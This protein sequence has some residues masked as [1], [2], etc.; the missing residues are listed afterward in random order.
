MIETPHKLEILTLGGLQ[1]HLDGSPLTALTP[2]KV[3]ALLVYLACADRPQ[4][5]EMLAELLWEDRDQAQ[6]LTN[7]RATL[8]RL[9]QHVAPFLSITRD[10]LGIEPASAVWLDVRECLQ[11]IAGAGA[12]QRLTSNDAARLEAALDLYHGDFL[13]D[14][15][16]AESPGFETW[17]AEQRAYLRDRVFEGFHRLVTFYLR[18]GAFLQ[19]IALTQ[20][21]LALD[22][23]SEQAH[24]QLM[25]LLAQSGQRSAA[26][27]QYIR[28]RQ[29]LAAELDVDPEPTTNA[30]YEQIQSG[31]IGLRAQPRL[32]RLPVMLTPFIGRIP[33]IEALRERL[34]SPDCRLLTLLGP[35]GIGK[36]RL[37][38][39]CATVIEEDFLDGVCVVQL[40][41]VAS[42]QFIPFVLAEVLELNLAGDKAI[43]PQIIRHL[44]DKELLIVAD[45][46][47]H[48]IDQLSLFSEI[49]R[50]APGVKLLTTSRERLNLEGEWVHAVH[51]MA[52]SSRAS[53]DDDAIQLFVQTARRASP[54]YR[55]VDITTIGE[56]CGLLDGLPLA[57]EM[58]AGWAGQLSAAEIAA[59]IRR[60]AHFLATN[61][62]DM[63]ERH[64]SM[65]NLF[66]HTWTLLAPAEQA[67]LNRLAVFRGDFDREAAEQITGAGVSILARLVE[68]S[69]VRGNPT[70]RYSL[71]ALIRQF[72]YEQL[73]ES[74][75]AAQ[76]H[77]AHLHYF[78]AFAETAELNL[79]GAGYIVW[80]R[81]LENELENIRTALA[82]AYENGEAESGLRLAAAIWI[83]WFRR[84]YMRE[85]LEWLTIGLAKTEG[86]TP[87]RTNALLGRV[88]F[89]A[90]V[91]DKNTGLYLQE[92]FAYAT[93]LGLKE[94]MA[95]CHL[96]MTFSIYDLASAAIHFE[97]ALTLLRDT[98]RTDWLALNLEQ[99]ADRLRTQGHPA[100][101]ETLYL[102]SLAVADANQSQPQ[103]I[104][105]LS[106]L[107][108]LAVLRGDYQQARKF[109]EEAVDAARMLGNR[110]DIGERLVHLGMLEC[111]ERHFDEAER[112]LEETLS[113]W[114]EIDHAMGISHVLHC[115]ADLSIQRGAFD[116]AIPLLS[117]CL[118]LSSQH[119]GNIANL[120]FNIVRLLL[121]ATI[122]VHFGANEAATVLLGA[123]ESFKVTTG[124][125]FDPVP[126]VEYDRLI[127]ALRR[128]GDQLEYLTLWNQG[129]LMTEYT[130][131]DFAQT[132]VTNLRMYIDVARTID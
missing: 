111:Y 5:R 36:T 103:R 94:F 120:E 127:A 100:R 13:A 14:F 110:V 7:L 69:L 57:I 8:S 102:E 25:L 81:R 117:E 56:I 109:M 118:K 75:L 121:V 66:A 27:K 116:Q 105:P 48:R 84:G 80:N 87:V 98:D 28:C 16:I 23:L 4:P 22:P 122:A 112:L 62:R 32:H 67:A 83:F 90:N 24:R 89:C 101:A 37:A 49:L 19:G 61:L 44:R 114:R 60:D 91:G 2:R 70:G 31:Q 45:N 106:N 21:L 79:R 93:Q 128:K 51:G 50:Q 39:Q 30:L 108:R 82:W 107:G 12:K 126:K 29:L 85:G 58:A 54:E 77:L 74:R 33:D 88:V 113:I 119:I 73:S 15:Y 53:L 26:L 41:G 47:E 86:V 123:T 43:D 35:G 1:L 104:N 96:D 9:K 65:H 115:L 38:Y 55:Q 78:I 125:A 68:K 72:A 34:N 97:T 6:S 124:F 20:R 76:T 46:C 64:R 17:V 99:Y 63:P 42:A 3:E 10:A 95:Q 132:T 11:V 59:Q 131:I 92:A 40:T 18:S 52:F 71:H 130:A 129:A